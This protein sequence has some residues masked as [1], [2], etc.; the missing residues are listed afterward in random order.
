MKTKKKSSAARKISGA[1]PAKSKKDFPA[2]FEAL[3]KIL[4]TY[5][6]HLRVIRYK[7]EFYYLETSVA[8]PNGKPLHFG[9][10]RLG[11]A[12]VSF[13]LM[14]VYMNPDL[15]KGMSAELKKRK[16]G[17]SCFNFTSIEPE[18]FREL[19]AL[20]RTGFEDYRKMKLV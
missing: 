1:K 3:R 8:G 14:P 16:Q 7:P 11:K 6:K 5:E 10:T 12:Y 18:L 19:A 13:Y 17:K 20:T 15:L 2:V 9:A 4:A